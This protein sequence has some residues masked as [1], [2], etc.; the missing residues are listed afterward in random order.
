MEMRIE[1][2]M[3]TC[4]LTRKLAPSSSHHLQLLGSTRTHTHKHK[5]A[6]IYW[7]S[8]VYQLTRYTQQPGILKSRLWMETVETRTKQERTKCNIEIVWRIMN[9]YYW[10]MSEFRKKKRKYEKRK[11]RFK[12]RRDSQ[13]QVQHGFIVYETSS[14]LWENSESMN[15]KMWEK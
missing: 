10:K 11:E 1:I 7:F 6:I 15:R 3:E 13:Q 4:M 5:R 14:L 8:V 12:R 9:S 2:L